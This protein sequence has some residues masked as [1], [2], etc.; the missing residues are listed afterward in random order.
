MKSVVLRFY[1]ILGIRKI[2]KKKKKSLCV[3]VCCWVLNLGPCACW[4]STLLLSQRSL[5]L[6]N[7]FGPRFDDMV[8]STGFVQSFFPLF[9]AVPFALIHDLAMD[10]QA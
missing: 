5:S 10:G 3:Y 4:V 6:R 2:I 9:E 7:T 8:Y 1:T